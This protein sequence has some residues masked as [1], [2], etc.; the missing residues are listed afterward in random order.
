M[1][2]PEPYE[3]GP[4]GVGTRRAAQLSPPLLL[5]VPAGYTEADR[6]IFFFG[7]QTYA[8]E[9]TRNL[10]ER[11]PQYQVD[12]PYTDISTLQ[13]FLANNDSVEALRWRYRVFDFSNNQPIN[14]RSPFWQAFREFQGWRDVRLVW[15]NL[16]CCDFQD[17]CILCAPEALQTYRPFLCFWGWPFPH[18]RSKRGN[19]DLGCARRSQFRS[20][21]AEGEELGTNILQQLIAC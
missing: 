3:F 10:H 5:S 20:E 7:Q 9:W 1:S 18:G 6:R 15:N 17:G 13:D 8:W 4:F 16:S 12:H 2:T 19:V 14:R 11:Y 21:A